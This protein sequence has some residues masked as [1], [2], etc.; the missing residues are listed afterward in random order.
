MLS[1]LWQIVGLFRW[2]LGENGMWRKFQLTE[3]GTRVPMLVSVPWL[4]ASFGRHSTV[5]AELVD[6]MPTLSDLA[7]LPPPVVHLGEAALDG[8]SL[9]HVLEHHGSTSGKGWALAV[10][11]RCPTDPKGEGLWYNNWCIQVPRENILVKDPRYA[12]I[13]TNLLCHRLF[14]HSCR[15]M[16]SRSSLSTWALGYS[17]RVHGWRFTAWQPWNGTTLQAVAWPAVKPANGSVIAHELLTPQQPLHNASEV[18]CGPYPAE[19]NTHTKAANQAACKAGGPE[20]HYNTGRGTAHAVC[21][22]AAECDCCRISDG[23]SPAAPAPLVYFEELFEYGD[24]EGAE[25]DLDELDAVEVA[26]LPANV[27]QTA[28]LY[29]QLRKYAL[30]RAGAEPLPKT[31]DQV[32]AAPGS[33]P[34]MAAGE[35]GVYRS[36]DDFDA[37]SLKTEDE[38]THVGWPSHNWSRVPTYAF[39]APASHSWNDTELAWLAGSAPADDFAPPPV[40]L[41]MGYVAGSAMVPVGEKSEAKQAAMAVQLRAHVPDL[42]IWFGTA[43]GVFAKMFVIGDYMKAHPELLLHCNGSLVLGGVGSIPSGIMDWSNNNTR[44]IWSGFFRTFMA[45]GPFSGVLIDGIGPLL[46]PYDATKAGYDI[47]SNP[48]CSKPEQDAWVQGLGVV[49]SMVR[50]AVGRTSVTMCNGHDQ[51]FANDALGASAAARVRQS[52]LWCN[53]N[54]EEEW[55]GKPA[56]IVLMLRAGQIDGYIFAARSVYSAD[57]SA[58]NRSLAAFLVAATKNQYF[59][60]FSGYD[61]GQQPGSQMNFYREYRLPL[62]PPT[63]PPGVPNWGGCDYDQCFLSRAYD[64]GSGK[65]KVLYNA[66]MD[67]INTCVE[68]ADGSDTNHGRGCE[69]ARRLPP[70]P[71]Q[72]STVVK[73]DDVVPHLNDGIFRDS[74]GWPGT[75]TG[76]TRW[77]GC[78]GGCW[79]AGR[80]TARYGCGRWAAAGW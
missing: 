55:A 80:T 69:Q 18:H 13:R 76:W 38:A 23:G 47:Y 73:H 72:L 63:T 61:C 62:G 66:T 5:I 19:P 53:A 52:S 43:W 46:P 35:R 41:A 2:A 37:P 64:H 39:C 32:L 59:L 28:K 56:D 31:D 6:V 36:T 20:Y 15:L 67:E 48:N 29:A 25:L 33:V 17:L 26:G 14:T 60:H 10:Y 34:A 50:D 22:Q 27:A 58:F 24:I 70:S 42:P 75:P 78:R 45:S 79:L 3:L 68:W 57:R 7:G 21:G 1:D 12:M 9:S 40:W 77:Q 74:V 4:P 71:A 49:S 16:T 65:V 8:V 11:P 30:G 51:L 54:F 44:K